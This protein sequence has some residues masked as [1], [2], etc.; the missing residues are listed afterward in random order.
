M[1][2]KVLFAS[3][4]LAASGQVLAQSSAQVGGQVFDENGDPVVGAQIMVKGS[5]TGTVTDIDGKFS[6]PSAKKGEAIVITYLGMDSQTL[7][8]APGM[9][10]SMHSQDRQL[11]EVIVVAYGEQKKSSFTG[12]AGVVNADKIAVRQVTNVVDALN[13]QVAGV[14]MINTSGN[15]SSTP[16]IRVRGISSINAGQDPLIVVDG[17]PYYGSWSDI[18]PA[19][20]ASVTVLKDAASNAL[21]GARGANGVIMITTKNPQVGKTVITVDAKWGSNSRGSQTYDM[22]SDPG[23]YYETHYKSLYNYYTN[24]KGMSAYAAHVAAN[25]ALGGSSEK[26]GLGYICYN[27]PEGQYL[28]GDNGKLNPNATLGNKISYNGKDYTISPDDWLKAAYRNTLRQEY[29]MNVNGGND[30]S[31]FYASLGYLDN[32]GIAYGSQFKRYT[33]RLKATYKANEWLKVGGNVNY[34]HTVTDN[35]TEVDS[36][37][38]NSTTNTFYMV[39]TIA[40]IYPLYLRDG[41]GNIMTDDN[42]KIYDYGNGMNAGLNRPVLSQLNLLKDDQLQASH[43]VGNTFGI[44][45][46]ADITPTFVK[47]LKITLNG[48]VDDYEYRYQSTKQPYYGFGATTYPNGEVTVGH[49]RYYTVN[50]Q[51]LVNY[52]RS[53]GLHNMTLLLGHENY[54]QTYEYVY[55]G[56]SNMFSFKENHELAGAITNE[57]TYSNQTNYNTEGF[58]FRGMYDYDGKYFGQVSYRRDGSSRFS[59]AHRWG[60][61]YSF[62]GAWILTKEDWMAGTK[63]WLD[64][65]K[66]KFSFGQQGNDAIGNNRYLDTYGIG[67]MNGDMALTFASK[68][69]DKITWETNTNI[70]AGLEFELFKGRLTGDVEY[71]YRKTT[72]M[73]CFIS[74]P[75]SMGYAGYYSNVGNMV[76]RGVELNLAGDVIR[77]KDFAWNINLNATHYTNEITKLYE[78]NKNEM[79]SGYAG[80][81]NGS[82]Y[83][84]EGLPIYTWRLKK[85]AGV[86]EKGE[87]TWYVENE[88][89]SLGKSAKWSEGSYF[90]CGAPTPDLYGGFGTSLSF[91]GID[92]GVN[93]TYSIGGKSYD[94]GY[95]SLMSVPHDSWTGFNFHKD[96]LD[97]WSP[98]NRES[99][100]PR[101]QYNDTDASSSSDRFLINGSYLNLQSINIGY[102]LPKS[103]TRRL[104]LTK[105]RVYGSADNVYLWSKRKGFDPRTSFTGSPSNEQ[106]AFVRTISGGITLQF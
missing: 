97:A 47:G 14:Q 88:D 67:S 95:Q 10:V 75:M 49:Y 31:Q 93:F 73:L 48:T 60:D 65:L 11:D 99:N 52:A 76:N 98:S 61:F 83:Y 45:G 4:L 7:K 3:L 80:Y 69:N 92:V 106:Y 77:T 66:V 96:M 9:K 78:E 44:N 71:F 53:F 63:S 41:N 35:A 59:P 13:G 34:A 85:Y 36:D 102:T 29:N 46:F 12:S 54:K 17:A 5:K 58:F 28:I 33:A 20:V 87:S 1:R 2:M 26:G 103:L 101:L 104:G 100:I 57:P 16:T 79:L 70:N 72:D 21:Y 22:I 84:G 68:G 30:S 43:S 39:N 64:M 50:F 42:G 94:S 19:D 18:N 91:K 55:G 38:N 105:V 82:Y 74:V 40:P 90:A 25:N 6:L 56:R 62:G 81:H 8:A 15:P 27:V 86:N 89:G 24:A 51:Q 23:Q 32:P 37:G